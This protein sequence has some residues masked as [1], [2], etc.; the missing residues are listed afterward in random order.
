[1]TTKEIIDFIL[2]KKKEGKAVYYVS[3]G[4][5][6]V[7][8][9]ED[10]CNQPADGILY[11]LNRDE[12]SILAFAGE[13]NPYWVNNYATAQVIRYLKDRVE[14]LEKQLNKEDRL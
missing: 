14:E 2:A 9:L 11:D 5:L 10:L 3:P 8:A 7:S 4:E 12:A 6:A 1:M 13:D